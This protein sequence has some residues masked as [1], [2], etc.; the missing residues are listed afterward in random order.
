MPIKVQA[1]VR[2]LTPAEEYESG[3]EF[4]NPLTINNPSQFEMLGA[5]FR[6]GNT[7]GFLA[8][9]STSDYGVEPSPDYDWS[10]SLDDAT[11]EELKPIWDTLE[12]EA[13]SDEHRDRLIEKYRQEK[14]DRETLLAGGWNA[15]LWEMGLTLADPVYLPLMFL[16]GGAAVRL[17]A[18]SRIGMATRW[19]GLAGLEEGVNEAILQAT[20]ISRP[21]DQSMR[22][23]GFATLFGGAVGGLLGMGHKEYFKF[24]RAGD[25]ELDK[26]VR[27]GGME[28]HPTGSMDE[29]DSIAPAGAIEGRSGG[30]ASAGPTLAGEAGPSL[31]PLPGGGGTVSLAF[32]GRFTPLTRMLDSPVP[33]TR[34]IANETMR[35]NFYTG[36]NM[37][38]RLGRDGRP[39]LDERGRPTY[40]HIENEIPLEV[41]IQQERKALTVQYTTAIR[42]LHKNL[43]RRGVKMSRKAFQAEIAKAMRRKDRHIIPEVQ[44]GAQT[45][46]RLIIDPMVN[47][48]KALGL[49][50]EDLDPK[51]AES[52]FPRVYDTYKIKKN[53]RE[54]NQLMLNHFRRVEREDRVREYIRE[55]VETSKIEAGAVADQEAADRAVEQITREVTDDFNA[56]FPEPEEGV[57][58]DTK[59]LRDAE[60][61]VEGLATQKADLDVAIGAA[62]TVVKQ[63]EENVKKAAKAWNSVR[64]R[65]NT[66]EK[67]LEKR[68]DWEGSPAQKAEEKKYAAYRKLNRRGEEWESWRRVSK[69]QPSAYSRKQVKAAE[70]KM[71]TARKRVEKAEA[72]AKEALAKQAKRIKT[73][74]KREVEKA[75]GRV[76]IEQRKLERLKER[77]AKA[78]E[79]QI[80]ALD[81]LGRRM[82]GMADT[83]AR[84]AAMR[85]GQTLNRWIRTA[86]KSR[87]KTVEEE[88]RQKMIDDAAADTLQ[89]LR[90][91]RDTLF[92]NADDVADIEAAAF[93]RAS[94]ATRNIL[95]PNNRVDQDVLSAP[96]VLMERVLQIEDVD[97]EDWLIDDPDAILQHF[98]RRSTGELGFYEKY[99]T[100]STDKLK[101]Q[102]QQEYDLLIQ[103][104][105]NKEAARLTKR[106]NEDFKD[107][108]AVADLL[109][110]RFSRWGDD[111]Q[112]LTNSAR[113]L[114]TLSYMARLGGMVI[115]ALPD[116]H[117]VISQHGWSAAIR[118]VG[119]TMMAFSQR[120]KLSKQQWLEVGVAAESVMGSRAFAIGMIDDYAGHATKIANKTRQAGALFTSLT[121]MNAWNTG[122]KMLAARAVQN[123][124]YKQLVKKGY[125]TLSPR[126]RERLARFGIGQREAD[127]MADQIRRHSEDLY[128]S[129]EFNT[130]NWDDPELAMKMDQIV[131]R[132]T[133]N[134]IV[135]PGIGDRPIFMNSQVGATLMQF[136]SF[137]FAS[138][139]H[140]TTANMQQLSRGQMSALSGMMVAGALAWLVEISKLA[141]AGRL[142]DL[143]YYNDNDVIRAVMDR[144][145]LVALPME[146]FNIADSFTAGGLSQSLD[147]NMRGLRYFDRNFGGAL[148]GP[149]V[150]YL[151]DLG[152]A[153]QGSA[154]NEFTQAD[155]HRLRRLLPMQNLFYMRQ[156]FNALEEGIGEEFR[157]PDTRRR[158]RL[159]AQ[160]PGR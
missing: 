35:H 12:R 104:A 15:T 137:F 56:R 123:D 8:T 121:L 42:K 7:L 2:P 151:T 19:A 68:D 51:F 83:E 113:L 1:R 128:G 74:A 76:E 160:P 55:Q 5:A 72:A 14:R 52:Y 106:M 142:E 108:D 136:K 146:V 9:P 39:I 109:L 116:L 47:R 81:S 38:L 43:K 124:I 62:E 135:T 97:L 50:P 111:S 156:A 107:L 87:G 23:I 31:L 144:S 4:Q 40:E 30:A 32:R 73:Q 125:S 89:R 28:P 44:E 10:A 77:R 145:G 58:P 127:R 85:R 140:A 134:T 16:P 99:G 130:R 45:Y 63:A 71:D 80:E 101:Q 25:Q 129:V 91:E 37:Q 3:P 90:N 93:D 22:E 33:S 159:V 86:V 69:E 70:A 122:M 110:N 26:I 117:R 61:R 67:W 20:Q 115:S 105:D 24:I 57:I 152:M 48:Y 36:K 29:L 13:V 95:A 103:A 53:M 27:D 133:E 114:R 84:R 138:W 154:L 66:G 120:A 112:H 102:I 34:K 92:R 59:G 75:Q 60:A 17:G 41:T 148:L 155:L 82:S 150:G 11:E 96:D 119:P 118:A 143:R 54:W 149:S 49:L 139:N 6:E 157:L 131:F 158:R 88:I 65:K 46:R 94:R 98:L 126:K 78:E 100:I 141:S 147:A 64:G 79:R 21:W 18:T 132:D 153:M